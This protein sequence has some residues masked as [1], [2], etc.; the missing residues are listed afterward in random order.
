MKYKHELHDTL[1]L[2]ALQGLNYV[3][4]LLVWP[5]LMVVLGAEKFGYI[6]FATAVCQYLMIV[7]DFGF[8]FT[9]T[10]EVALHKDDKEALTK[11]FWTTLYAKGFLL[12]ICMALL[13]FLAFCVPA[14]ESYRYVLLIMSGMVIAHA[15]SFVWLFQGLGKIRLI[16]I[17]NAGSK[18]LILPMTFVLVH[19]PSHFL[20]AALLLSVVYI[21]ASLL[22]FLVII[23]EKY[24]KSFTK[25]TL[26][27][28]KQM[29]KNSFPVFLSQASTTVYTMMFV[30]VLAYFVGASDVGRYT[31][32]EK[33]I[34]S[35]A[36]LFLV[37]IVQAFFPRLSYMSI[38]NKSQAYKLIRGL[39]VLM[40]VIMLIVGC[41]FLFGAEYLC[42]FLGA[43]YKDSE[44][45]FQIMSMLPLLMALGGIAGQLGLLALGDDKEKRYFRNVYV[46][47]AL[48][49]LV[50]M[51]IAIPLYGVLGTAV[52]VLIVESFV[53]LVMMGIYFKR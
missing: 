36:Y 7:V 39:L 45:L 23:R 14:Y 19:G 50:I 52:A 38:T 18:L 3:M 40:T 43:D 5:Y 28:V 29:L 17:V 49:A 48:L 41:V 51:C 4:P 2:V 21:I 6:G 37:P 10:K 8:N 46:W 35:V 44:N 26:I 31:A 47:A 16:S 15:F 22:G 30:V 13:L 32:V 12:L 53:C 25:V 42:L 24:V 34:R 33:L 11:I 27:E 9:A 20:L 1:W